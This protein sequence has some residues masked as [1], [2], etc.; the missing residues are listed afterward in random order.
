[1]TKAGLVF[2]MLVVLAAQTA[3]AQ[4]HGFGQDRKPQAGQT[5]AD[6][7]NVQ[8]FSPEEYRQR[9][10]DFMIEKSGLTKEESDKFFP[11]YFELQQKKNEI[12]AK[13]RQSVNTSSEHGQLTDE[14]YTRMIDNLADA[15]LQ[16]AKLEKEYLEKFKKVVPASKLLRLQIAETQFGSEMIKE[17]QRSAQH[18]MNGM[19]FPGIMN[20]QN[21]MPAPNGWM[22][23]G[24]TMPGSPVMPAVP[25]NAGNRPAWPAMPGTPDNSQKQSTNK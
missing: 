13:S 24:G 11:I 18:M 20:M 1:M 23:F 21:R 9:Q 2:S 19:R 17:M 16:T 22:N 14:D 10:Q 7:H 5:V 8:H 12:N 3:T 15:K 25:G 4:F 6:D